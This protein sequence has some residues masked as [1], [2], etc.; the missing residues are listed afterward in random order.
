MKIL[1]INTQSFDYV[2]DLTYSGLVKKFG[3]NNVIDYRW[4]KKFHLQYAKYPKNNGYIKGSFFKSLFRIVNF[5]EFDYVFVGSCKI[6]T[7]QTY[8]QIAHQI[9]V[10]T[11]VV[12]IDGGDGAG[13][14][15][16]IIS[17]GHPTLFQEAVAV[18]PFDLI[19][20]REYF[21]DEVYS[22]NVFPLPMCFNFDRLPDIINEYKY[23]F[24]FWAVES[25]PI[26]TKALAILENE[27]DCK[28]NGTSRNQRFSKYKRKG[29]FYLQELAAC[30]ITLNLRGGG[31]DTMRYWEVPAV[32]GFMMSQK[33][34]IV[35]P[36]NFEH[37][38]EVVF[39]QDDLSD[40]VELG[41]YYLKHEDK[42]KEIAKN[43]LEK[44]LAYHTDLKRAE[45][46][47]ET[48][49]WFNKNA[50]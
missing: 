9:P 21:T 41:K 42:R 45:Y 33:P 11:K 6:E 50:E 3:L 46:I 30:K 5:K 13:I 23:D 40:L 28:Q 15:S 14:G 1:Y 29:D 22:K 4:N 26:R 17:Y 32:G 10:K 27:F 34:G 39:V 43:G 19:F 16:D 18:R 12:L 49:D 37:E 31:W 36:N 7:F 25:H 44:M 48:I 35:I 20:K 24:S 38:K 2:Q 47:F 8:M